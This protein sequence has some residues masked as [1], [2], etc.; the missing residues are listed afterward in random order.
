MP[1]AIK[2]IGAALANRLQALLSNELLGK[3]CRTTISWRLQISYNLL[4]RYELWT[5][6]VPCP[7]SDKRPI[8]CNNYQRQHA[9]L[10]ARNVKR[11]SSEIAR[12]TLKALRHQFT[13]ANLK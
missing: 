12:T 2:V 5:G 3:L 10:Y 9:G 4:T 11:K 1:A 8:G 13:L 7:D 6:S